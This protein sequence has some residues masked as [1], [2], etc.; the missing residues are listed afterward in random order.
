MN[1]NLQVIVTEEDGR[2]DDPVWLTTQAELS[3]MQD[4]VEHCV[5]VG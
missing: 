1:E 3:A 2:Y 4:A 5:S